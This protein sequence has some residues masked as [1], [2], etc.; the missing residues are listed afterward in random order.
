MMWWLSP[1]ENRER[2][3]WSQ[4]RWSAML[5]IAGVG[6]DLADSGVRIEVEGQGLQPF[7]I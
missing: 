3:K 7:F 1:M 4:R 6:C 2:Q 5:E